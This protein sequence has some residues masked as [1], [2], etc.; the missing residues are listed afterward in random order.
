MS[1][2]IDATAIEDKKSGIYIAIC[3][4]IISN[5]LEIVMYS[6]SHF[7]CLKTEVNISVAKVG[8]V[9]LVE[10]IIQAFI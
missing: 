3:N 10:H 8:D 5:A 4:I 7:V 6:A 2:N 1:L 9:V